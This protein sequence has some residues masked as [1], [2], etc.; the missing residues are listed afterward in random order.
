MKKHYGLIGHPLG[1][2]LSPFIHDE[3]MK[4]CHIDGIY[5]V[6]DI[7]PEEFDCKVRELLETQ[8]GLNV[9]IPYKEAIVP[10]LTDVDETACQI[11]AVNTVHNF[12]IK[13]DASQMQIK[14]NSGLD[15]LSMG[16][17]N[18]DNDKDNIKDN[19]N[20]NYHSGFITDTLGFRAC[21]IPIF[22]KHVLILGAG[23]VA[24]VL[25]HEAIRAGA[26]E[27]TIC[28]RRIEQARNLVKE[29]CPASILNACIQKDLV[30]GYDVILNA[31]PIGMWPNCNGI[32]VS[33]DIIMAAKYVFD[34]IYNPLATKLV[35]AA[36]SYGIKSQCGLAMLYH[37]ALEAQRIWNPLVDFSHLPILIH[38]ENLKNILLELFPVKFILTGFMGSGKTTIGKALARKL[39][40]GFVDLDEYIVQETKKTI[41]EIFE[42]EGEIEFRKIEKSCLQKLMDEQNTLI[43]ATGGG[44]LIDQDNV[45]Y[46]KKHQGFIFFLSIDLETILTR[47][48]HEKG[49]PLFDGASKETV[50][51]LYLERFPVYSAIADCKIDANGT[52]DDVSLKIAEILLN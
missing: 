28:A 51:K 30:P 27:I 20:Y 11:G 26:K 41:P 17:S 37:Q 45:E 15:S 25:L 48:S 52:I 13:N 16:S 5:L 49:R 10:F 21:E 35:L 1:H 36:R 38:Q 47:I 50:A 19:N 34:T 46:V 43:I 18:Y 44:A 9:T 22:Q 31:T 14:V 12:Q 39:N 6:Y 32:P 33:R 24:R 29:F 8:D 3:I 7:A 23:G 4:E 2:T 40:V 42:I